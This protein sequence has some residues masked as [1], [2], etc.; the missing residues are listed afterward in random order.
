MADISMNEGTAGSHFNRQDK[1]KDIFDTVIRGHWRTGGTVHALFQALQD[2][3]AGGDIT[4]S[5]DITDE[6]DL[7]TEIERIF[8]AGQKAIHELVAM[9]LKALA[10]EITLRHMARSTGAFDVGPGPG[11]AGIGPASPFIGGLGAAG[12][13]ISSE[14][15]ELEAQMVRAS[16]VATVKISAVSITGTAVSANIGNGTLLTST[17]RGD[18]LSNPHVSGSKGKLICG[19]YGG[20]KGG[21]TNHE[22]FQYKDAAGP[23]G[24]HP[25]WMEGTR[26]IRSSARSE[27][28]PEDTFHRVADPTAYAK[29]GNWLSNSNFN[30]GWAATGSDYHPT[31]W[32]KVL[33][34]AGTDYR[35]GSTVYFT[36][37]TYS[38]ELL[39][40]TG[41]LTAFKQV[42]GDDSGT[43]QEWEGNAVVGCL[44][45]LYPNG[46]ITGGV[47]KLHVC[48]SGGTTRNDDQGNAL[49]LSSTLSGLTPSAWNTVSGIFCIPRDIADTDQFRL[50][51][52]SA[53]TGNN[54]FIAS[55]ILTPLQEAYQ[56]GFK[57]RLVAGSTPFVAS[58]GRRPADTFDFT[59]A[60]DA[61][62]QSHRRATWQ[63]YNA[64]ILDGPKY[65]VAWPETTG[66]A[67]AEI[68]D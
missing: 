62:G 19:K 14:A 5:G 50:E 58:R 42:F 49:S 28:T 57:L 53:L 48:T 65:G 52:T 54:L 27:R 34:T 13:D 1:I 12:K 36:G 35:R 20:D 32:T 64:A 29:R 26:G 60:N 18:G 23:D 6:R 66:T 55:T 67:T 41:V 7:Q 21:Y 43:A 30:D 9:P 44:V 10:K 25:D 63:G 68:V 22:E 3:M 24:A 47:L 33:G 16:P 39:A 11:D 2:V 17:K 4:V 61:G 8:L 51:L 46:A 15:R 45:R 59:G 38:L 56:G 40:G 31:R 37:S